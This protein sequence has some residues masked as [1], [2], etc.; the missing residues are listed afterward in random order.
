MGALATAGLGDPGE[1]GECM[2]LSKRCIPPLG[3]PSTLK[4]GTLG[5]GIGNP[6]AILCLRPPVMENVWLKGVLIDPS[7]PSGLDTDKVRCFRL[8]D[9]LFFLMPT[10]GFF[11][12]FGDPGTRPDS[13]D[14]A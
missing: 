9:D 12:V 11:P 5:V 14:T 10:A 13:I 1:N 2:S 3:S 6:P 7:D 4:V 8:S